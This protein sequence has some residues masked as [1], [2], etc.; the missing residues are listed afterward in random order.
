M[1]IER[2]VQC[3]RSLYAMHS[4]ARKRH[5][6]QRFFFSAWILPWDY[7]HISA[8]TPPPHQIWI[9][10]RDST[11]VWVNN[12]A[13][14]LRLHNLRWS[15]SGWNKA[16]CVKRVTH[17]NTPDMPPIC[18]ALQRES[19]KI[20]INVCADC[21][22]WLWFYFVCVLCICVLVVVV[23][24]CWKALISS[25]WSVVVANSF[26]IQT[27]TCNTNTR[28]TCKRV[29]CS[30]C[31]T[32][33]SPRKGDLIHYAHS[34]RSVRRMCRRMLFDLLLMDCRNQRAARNIY[35]AYACGDKAPHF[36]VVV[37]SVV[38]VKCC[39]WLDTTFV[40]GEDFYVKIKAAISIVR[41][42]SKS[43]ALYLFNS[44]I[45]IMHINMHI[46]R[47]HAYRIIGCKLYA[48]EH[49]LFTSSAAVHSP[50]RGYIEKGCTTSW[51]C[52]SS[53][54]INT[55]AIEFI[56]SFF[57]EYVFV[58]FYFAIALAAP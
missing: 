46:H 10:A 7:V 38:S 5:I 37:V 6:C 32:F 9:P 31:Y 26:G 15:Y 1:Y 23:C 58:C 12:C 27:L 54:C 30:I 17:K 19:A 8:T 16:R 56:P 20:I 41:V 3:A 49:A 36:Y 13:R 25:A 14:S 40:W 39:E 42:Q 45:E 34:F 33:P 29:W 48:D 57:F 11:T 51:I 18:R 21:G 28:A 55:N 24:C 52:S 47:K 50:A 22:E 44:A 35:S 53:L 2:H 43:E 4:C